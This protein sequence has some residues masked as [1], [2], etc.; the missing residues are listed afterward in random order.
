MTQEAILIYVGISKSISL[1]MFSLFIFL[2]PDSRV[3]ETVSEL[4]CTVML[5]YFLLGLGEGAKREIW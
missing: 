2:E 3:K 4:F 5:S 1:D